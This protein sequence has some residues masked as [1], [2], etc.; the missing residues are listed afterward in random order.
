MTDI[1]MDQSQTHAVQ[2]GD[3][4]F[5]FLWRQHETEAQIQQTANSTRKARIHVHPDGVVEVETPADATLAEVKGALL[6]RARW[7]T[8][9]LRE[10]HARQADLHHRQYVSG[11]SVFYLGRRYVLKVV[12]DAGNRQVKMLRGQV[13]VV[14]PNTTRES[15]RKALY[16]WYRA[17]A[18]EVFRR[19]IEAVGNALPWIKQVPSWSIRE[20]QTQWGS[21]SP[22]GAILLNP[23]LVKTPTRC[24]DYV[25]LH[26]L[27][28][29]KEHN[30]SPRFYSLLDQA[31]P[32]WQ[33]VKERLDGVSDM[34]LNY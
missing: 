19:R 23:H 29:L 3:Q 15:V 1:R 11:E 33:K 20:M 7:I 12:K 8:R 2:Y 14:V 27:C 22:G 32:D 16:Q 28:H 25:I 4:R 18:H 6:K 26:E 9:H 34:Y 21:C 13:R 24:I 10:I 5:Q 30:H 17:R 31:M